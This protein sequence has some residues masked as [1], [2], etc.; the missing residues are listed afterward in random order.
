MQRDTVDPIL[1]ADLR[2]IQSV[3]FRENRLVVFH[4]AR[5]RIERFENAIERESARATVKIS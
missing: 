1:P 4:V 2:S 3:D 5:G